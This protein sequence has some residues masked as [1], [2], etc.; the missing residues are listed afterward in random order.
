MS[1]SNN[2]KLIYQFLI[3]EAI[4]SKKVK[5]YGEVS[6]ATGVPLGPAG[7]AVT[8]ALYEIFRKC[9][10]RLLPPLSAIVV[11]DESAY[12]HGRHGMTGGG[13]LSAEAESPNHAGRRRDK[14][15]ERWKE[16][17]RPKDGGI[18]VW[19][20]REMIQSHQDMVWDYPHQWPEEL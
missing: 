20:M 11:Q 10:D 18:E 4:P 3:E 5:T 19:G 1:L 13:Y 15:W 2:S 6:A 12:D 9:D 14:G 16:K 17:P 8:E 7:G